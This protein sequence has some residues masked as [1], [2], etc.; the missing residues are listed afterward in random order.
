MA[1][2]EEMSMSVKGLLHS[3][4]QF[5]RRRLN[6]DHPI[7]SEHDQELHRLMAPRLRARQG[8]QRMS[9]SS[10]SRAPAKH[11]QMDRE[12]PLLVHTASGQVAK[13]GDK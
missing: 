11:V 9:G 12:G 6:Q 4:S 8:R 10:A 1:G 13:K 5:S 2:M 3:S 7:I